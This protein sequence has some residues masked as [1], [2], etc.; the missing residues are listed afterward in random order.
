MHI[1]YETLCLASSIIRID[2]AICPPFAVDLPFT[3]SYDIAYDTMD[4]RKLARIRGEIEAARRKPQSQDDLI[5]LAERLG[6]T[7]SK[8]G[9]EPTWVTDLPDLF[10]L[11]IPYAKGG[12]LK[13][14]TKKSIL[15]QLEGDVLAWDE[16]LQ[17][18]ENG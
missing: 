13:P 12:D 5:R 6:R 10:P 15:N 14:G 1:G 9:K 3:K 18:R 16:I 2:R 4:A 7:R 11:S 8:R 17:E